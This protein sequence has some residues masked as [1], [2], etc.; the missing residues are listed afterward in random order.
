LDS[1]KALPPHEDHHQE[2]GERP[3]YEHER[4]R[5]ESALAT[6]R[7]ALHRALETAESAQEFGLEEDLQALNAEAQRIMSDVMGST[8][9]T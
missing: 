1:S 2:A 8:R 9:R 7:R 3:M 4:L 5:I 6:V